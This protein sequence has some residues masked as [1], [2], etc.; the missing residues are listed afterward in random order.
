[1]K[2]NE[3]IKSIMATNPL[4]VNITQKLSEVRKLMSEQQIHHVPVVSGRKLVGLLSAT[5]MV[6]LSFSAY[7]ADQRAVDAMLDHEFTIEKVM[8]TELTTLQDTST[9]RDAAKILREGAFH[10]LPVIDSEGALLGIVTSTDLI[11]Y[12]YDQY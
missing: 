3:P 2:R 8:Q 9:V 4:T 7:G 11:R 1:M 12:L 6:R 10:S 5:D